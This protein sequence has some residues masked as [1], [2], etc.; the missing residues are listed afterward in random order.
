MARYQIPKNK[1]KVRIVESRAGTPLVTN[2]I[3]GKSKI[4]IP[5]RDIKHANEVLDKILDL[6]E[7]GELWV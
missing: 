2:D 7:G 5:C 4:S 1:G 6:R 3:R